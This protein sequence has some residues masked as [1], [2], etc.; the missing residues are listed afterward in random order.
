MCDD[1]VRQLASQNSG[2]SDE[3]VLAAAVALLESGGVLPVD[4]NSVQLVVEHKLGEFVGAVSS[5]I[6][7]G[8]RIFGGS[9][10]THQ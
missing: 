10:G 1:V 5:I 9:E 3:P 7:R 8:G 4:I 6:P 2:E